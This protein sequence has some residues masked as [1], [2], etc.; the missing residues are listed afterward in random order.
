MTDESQR[1]IVELGKRYGRDVVFYEIG[2]IREKIQGNVDT[3]G[4]DISV[5]ARLFTSASGQISWKISA[6][7]WAWRS[8]IS[9]P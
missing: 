6:A 7:F 9:A 3:K 5:L 4:F 8:L 1:K 2:D